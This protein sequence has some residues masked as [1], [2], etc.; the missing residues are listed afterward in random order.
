[1]T[2]AR[3]ILYLIKVFAWQKTLLQ[4]GETQEFCL[5]MLFPVSEI[6]LSGE[7]KTEAPEISEMTCL[8]VI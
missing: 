7:F 3:I 2:T 1:M 8:G 5:C 4:F 6:T